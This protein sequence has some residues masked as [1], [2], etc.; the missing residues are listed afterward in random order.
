MNGSF[1]SETDTQPINPNLLD[2]IQQGGEYVIYCGEAPLAMPSGL[3]PSHP[4]R[5]LLEHIVRELLLAGAADFKAVNG[6][7]L[8]QLCRRMRE[9]S[10]CVIPA[11]MRHAFSQDPFL[12][13]DDDRHRR[14][15]N[16]SDLIELIDVVDSS[17]VF[18]FGSVS[19]VVQR[20]HDFVASLKPDDFST[21]KIMS[22]LERVY[23]N[24]P[25]EKQAAVI[26]LCSAH[27]CGLVLPLMLVFGKITP[28]E[29]ACTLFGAHLP[30]HA[31]DETLED[32]RE[33]RAC[34][35]V[36]CHLPDWHNITGSYAALRAE[37]MSVIEYLWYH[38]QDGEQA[39]GTTGLIRGGENELAEFKSSLRWNI[40]AERKDE[41]VEHAALKT[42]AAFLNSA[43]GSLLVGVADD[44][45]ILGIEA[46]QF[47]NTDK[48]AQHFWNLV[49]ETLSQEIA[50]YVHTRFERIGDKTVFIAQCL[51]SPTPVFLNHK[52]FGEE[53][54]IRVGP[55][56]VKL[57][58]Q[59]SLR[60]IARRFQAME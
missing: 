3:R 59:E 36:S 19:G 26:L 16:A 30:H 21:P 50:P 2:V 58:I 14:A 33:L 11:A 27:G 44:G 45:G 17:I 10:E 9:E 46:D 47:Q 24:Q 38:E 35:G 8:F 43:G 6:L 54:Y 51:K 42:I 18:L 25:T 28:S 53:F 40:K 7:A 12:W 41:S 31:I 20:F 32:F 1:K 5:R 57:G 23:D 37:A 4:S 49:R 13:R 56:S 55:G 29:Y 39:S 48:F 15:G 60:Y 22:A 34:A 52:K